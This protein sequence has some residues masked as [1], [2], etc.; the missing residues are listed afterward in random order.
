MM[1][2]KPSATSRRAT[3][4]QASSKN[5]HSHHAN[6]RKAN[7]P[8]QPAPVSERLKRLFTSL[9]AQIDGGHFA[10]AVKTCDKSTHAQQLIV[11]I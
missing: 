4:S 3:K 10:N 9:C 5:A 1:A 6:K 2:P 8:K 7:T 11:L